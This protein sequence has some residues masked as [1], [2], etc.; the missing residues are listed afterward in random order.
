MSN[1]PVEVQTGTALDC[2]G[3]GSF[4]TRA[5]VIKTGGTKGRGRPPGCDVADVSIGRPKPDPKLSGF[6][7]PE[8]G[9]VYC[10]QLV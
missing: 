1:R 6:P 7:P 4:V 2:C 3:S 5:R 9:T 8:F 10:W